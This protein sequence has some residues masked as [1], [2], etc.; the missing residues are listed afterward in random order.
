MK[1]INLYFL[2]RSAIL[3]VVLCLLCASCI[4]LGGLYCGYNQLSDEQKQQVKVLETFIENIVADGNIYLVTHEQVAAFIKTHE[5]VLIYEYTPWCSAENCANPHEVAKLCKERGSAFLLISTTLEDFSDLLK[6]KLPTFAINHHAYQTNVRSKY[7]RK[8]YDT[9][10]GIPEKE[11]G[12]GS[13]YI[14]RNGQFVQAYK[15]F[16]DAFDLNQ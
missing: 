7:L 3:L 15:N 2:Y 11:R 16:R 4:S 8:F 12:L 5:D 1:K 10:T 6:L 9:L 14:F 13:Y